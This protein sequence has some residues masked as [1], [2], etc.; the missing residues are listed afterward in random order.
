MVY[1]R[2]DVYAKQESTESRISRVNRTGFTTLKP[3][4]QACV[5]KTTEAAQTRNHRTFHKLLE[6]NDTFNTDKGTFSREPI[7]Q[8]P[9]GWGGLSFA[10][11]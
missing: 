1:P 6:T 8:I 10:A 4:G 3:G 9:G 5:M 11:I 2:N 7:Y